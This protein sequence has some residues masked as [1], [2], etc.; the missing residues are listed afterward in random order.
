M[1]IELSPTYADK[2]L[3]SIPDHVPPDASLAANARRAEK[4][5]LLD[6]YNMVRNGGEWDYK[7][8]NPRYAR[9]GNLNYGVITK[10]AGVPENVAL[11]GA[12]YAQMKA[13][14]SKF[15][16]SPLNIPKLLRDKD[17]GD[18]PDDQERIRLGFRAFDLSKDPKNSKG[19]DEKPEHKGPSEKTGRP[20]ASEPKSDL[21]P[22]GPLL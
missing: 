16:D 13:D 22:R 19:L 17:Y 2:I 14:T 3:D 6:L 18:D 11:A 9:F 10:A 8:E 20:R 1:A 21:A 15:K 5:S 4:Q 7:Q 12:G